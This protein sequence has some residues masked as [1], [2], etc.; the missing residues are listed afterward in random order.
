MIRR[1]VAGLALTATLAACST[2]SRFYTLAVEPPADERSREITIAVAEIV[3]PEYLD[4]P[5]IVTREGPTQVRIGEIDRWAESLAPLLQ[6]TLGDNLARL[7]GAEEI[8][9]LPQRRDLPYDVLVDVEV[10][11]FDADEA[12]RAVLD[13][14][15]RVFGRDGE[16]MLSTDR[17]LIADTGAPPPDYP[18]IVAAMSRTVTALAEAVASGIPGAQTASARA[19]RRRP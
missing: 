8:L 17:V 6:R 14:R 3:L 9:L 12:G 11:R 15:W 13:A 2:P 5:E 16:E 4:R 18:A 19:P 1:W 7:T 10:R